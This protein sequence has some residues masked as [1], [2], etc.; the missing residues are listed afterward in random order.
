[1]TEKEYQENLKESFRQRLDFLKRLGSADI[2][3]TEFNLRAL[4]NQCLVDITVA[5]RD[6]PEPN[7]YVNSNNPS[8]V[9][10]PSQRLSHIEA[11]LEELVRWFDGG[12][13]PRLRGRIS[14]YSIAAMLGR[15]PFGG[16]WI[17]A[18]R[19]EVEVTAPKGRRVTAAKFYKLRVFKRRHG[20]LAKRLRVR[21]VGKRLKRKWGDWRDRPRARDY[22]LRGRRI[23]FVD[24][25]SQFERIRQG[26]IELYT[27]LRTLN[28]ER[29]HLEVTPFER[30]WPTAFV[31]LFP[32]RLRPFEREWPTAFTD[33]VPDRHQEIS[34]HV[35]L[36]EIESVIANDQFPRMAEASRQTILFVQGLR[37]HYD[38]K[39]KATIAKWARCEPGFALISR[40]LDLVWPT[41]KGHP[42]SAA[43]L[44]DLQ[45]NLQILEDLAANL[46]AETQ[47]RLNNF[48]EFKKRD[49]D[50]VRRP[51][52]FLGQREEA[53]ARDILA[54]ILDLRSELNAY[55]IARDTIDAICDAVFSRA[56]DKLNAEANLVCASILPTLDNRIAARKQFLG[57]G[58]DLLRASNF[59][60][61]GCLDP[62]KRLRWTKAAE[63]AAT[64]V[65]EADL[66][67]DHHLALYNDLI[68]SL[69]LKPDDL[70][71]WSMLAEWA[72]VAGRRF[73]R[74]RT[75]PN[76]SSDS[77]VLI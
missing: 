15:A 2:V 54:L 43:R 57:F 27:Q 1:M 41:A 55:L 67:Q 47:I 46:V 21:N 9:K 26:Q 39:S 68:R 12:N 62:K 22:T 63:L 65:A 50:T 76:F 53:A 16:Q 32:D 35:S 28:G 64:V 13:R 29:L 24:M 70:R 40:M 60:W 33:R 56:N 49:F 8:H 73:W 14:R 5:C 17:A 66:N 36:N 34:R 31:D 37:Q 58:A 75:P 69:Q 38:Q 3:E 52:H 48:D 45:T 44:Y 18:T 23:Y 10:S 20:G 7:R 71:A 61:F 4:V 42:N 30:E 6:L 51:H 19:C 74:V 77:I 25:L 59:K 11:E 72:A